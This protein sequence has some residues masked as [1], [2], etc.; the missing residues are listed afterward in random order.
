MKFSILS[1]LTTTSVL[2]WFIALF[3]TSTGYRGTFVIV[4]LLVVV[5]LMLLIALLSPVNKHGVIE[6]EKNI[7]FQALEPTFRILGFLTAGLVT[8][9]IASLAIGG[10]ALIVHYG[11]R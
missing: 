9:L 5:G 2:G 8:I 6:H 4:S 1:L 7:L 3:R 11:M 10:C